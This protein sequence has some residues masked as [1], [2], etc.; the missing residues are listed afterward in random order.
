MTLTGRHTREG[1]EKVD[2]D[3]DPEEALRAAHAEMLRAE[4]MDRT[5]NAAWLKAGQRTVSVREQVSGYSMALW[6][7]RFMRRAH[8]R[9]AFTKGFS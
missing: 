4:R 3:V 2:Y 7:A 9:K 1:W 5:R 8:E 6:R